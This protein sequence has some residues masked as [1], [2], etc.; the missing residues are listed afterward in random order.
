MEQSIR[1]VLITDDHNLVRFG[2]AH[3]MGRL[4]PGAQILHAVN[5][6]D[7]TQ[8]VRA[9]PDL[10]L[11][12]VDLS[13]PDSNGLR[14]IE[15]VQAIRAVLPIVVISGIEDAQLARRAID[16]GVLGPVQTGLNLVV[17]TAGR[18]WIYTTRLAHKRDY[19]LVMEEGD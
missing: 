14:V 1:K 19:A 3:L 13:L 8:L 15:E 2:I 10:G 16:L 7:T 9:N 12:V 17:L 5:R 18:S 11:L 4:L 6:L